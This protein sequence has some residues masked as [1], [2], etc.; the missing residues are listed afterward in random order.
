MQMRRHYSPTILPFPALNLVICISHK[1]AP[2]RERHFLF[3][4]ITKPQ[5]RKHLHPLRIHNLKR[6][7]NDQNIKNILR[8]QSLD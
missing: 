3:R 7:H 8:C 6:L 1:K 4:H 2:H 5:P